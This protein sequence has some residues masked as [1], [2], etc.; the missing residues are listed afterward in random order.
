[1]NQIRDYPHC[2][3]RYSFQYL[4]EVDVDPQPNTGLSSMSLAKEKEGGLYE[5]Q[6]L[7]P[8]NSQRQLT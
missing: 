8:G 3:Q 1:M 2:H 7:D 5:S 6:G 4:L